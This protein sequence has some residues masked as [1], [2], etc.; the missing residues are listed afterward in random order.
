MICGEKFAEGDDIVV[1]PDCGTPYHRKCYEEKGSCI[2]T[3]LH[4][5]DI[6]WLPDAP[7]EQPIPTVAASAVKRCI[8]CGAENSN[9][10]RYCEQCGTP[11]INMDTPRPFNDTA[12][13]KKTAG[14]HISEES[15]MPH[16]NG[17][18]IQPVMLNQDSDID[19]VKLGDLARYVGSNPIGFLPSFIKFAKT[20]RK[21]SMNLFAFLFTPVYF[22]YRKMTGWGIAFGALMALLG[23]PSMI[24]LLESGDMGYKIDMGINVKSQDFIAVSQA[25]MLM[26]V[27]VKVMAC[28]FA[29]YLYYKQARKQIMRIH[30]ESEGK[31][32]DDVNKEIILAGGTSIGYMV[33]GYFFYTIVTIGS[34]LVLAKILS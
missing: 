17:L 30:D 34:V 25:L 32:S 13:S 31:S 24:E 4:D 21:L 3:V 29:N 22:M 23:V 28:F 8:R 1:C 9:D 7:E 2:N 16:L 18:D 19:G 26:T 5:K 20:G 33:L 12:S 15:S 6:G 10:R 14:A 27:A 11:L